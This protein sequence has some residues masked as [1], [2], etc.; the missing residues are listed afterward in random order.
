MN[1]LNAAIQ[2]L[3]ESLQP[4]TYNVYLNG[5]PLGTYNYGARIEVNGD[6]YRQHQ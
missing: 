4:M 3:L 6:G 2:A 5:T 1:S